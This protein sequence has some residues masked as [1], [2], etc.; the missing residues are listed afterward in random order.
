MAE[1]VTVAESSSNAIRSHTFPTLESGNVSFPKGRYVVNLIG[2]EDRCSFTVTHRLEGAPLVQQLLSE[3]KAIHAC[4]VSSPLS[5]YR[6]TH[7]STADSHVVGWDNADLGESPLL[8]P[9]VVCR[10]A[11]GMKLDSIEHGVH[12]VWSN[13][14]VEF[15]KGNRLAVSHVIQLQASIFHLLSFRA[16]PEIPEGAFRV[17]PEVEN[18]FRFRVSLGPKLHSHLRFPSR[19]SARDHVMTHIVSASFAFLRNE[20]GATT[21]PLGSWEEHRSL[22]LLAEV[23]RSRQLPV[24]DEDGFIPEMVATSVYPHRF[25]SVRVEGGRGE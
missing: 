24:W 6:Q 8:T 1:I 11:F 15:E 9:M 2:R 12:P 10:Q 25:A 17:E 16:D 21:S 22:R 18:G 3:G 14:S 23:L 19:D 13:R 4:V 7:L 20:F 5:S